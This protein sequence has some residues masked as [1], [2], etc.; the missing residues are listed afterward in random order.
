MKV[1]QEDITAFNQSFDIGLKYL[2]NHVRAY[3]RELLKMTLESKNKVVKAD[4]QFMLDLAEEGF[5]RTVTTYITDADKSMREKR[6]W[7]DQVKNI[8]NND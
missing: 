2:V 8:L 4:R 7:M 6:D 5:I 3:Q 1:I